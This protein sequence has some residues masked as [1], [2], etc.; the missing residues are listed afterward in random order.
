MVHVR[1]SRTFPDRVCRG[2]CMAAFLE[3][4][5]VDH[6]VLVGNLTKDDEA[7]IK[8]EVSTLKRKVCVCV[9]P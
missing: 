8:Q 6:D 9:C 3:D 1:S 7:R 5:T 2:M 4:T